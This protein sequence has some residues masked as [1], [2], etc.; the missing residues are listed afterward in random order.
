MW[1]LAVI[2][3]LYYA[4]VML[5]QRSLPKYLIILFPI[6]SYL[7][8]IGIRIYPNFVLAVVTLLAF[9]LYVSWKRNLYH[10][11]SNL[12][13]LVSGLL[14][15]ISQAMLETTT[16]YN[17]I[18]PGLP[19]RGD[20]DGLWV[21]IFPSIVAAWLFAVAVGSILFWI[22][23]RKKE[24][25][26]VKQPRYTKSYALVSIIIIVVLQILV[27]LF[28]QRYSSAS[29]SDSFS[30]AL[31]YRAPLGC[32]EQTTRARNV[33]T[34]VEFFFGTECIPKGWEKVDK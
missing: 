28:S 27:G 15:A 24:S 1:L 4:I 34:G 7:S 18:G 25:T 19:L 26:G 21:L 17:G 13:I 22:E 30:E 16:F 2:A 11:L 33:R 32:K 14:G 10:W 29:A 12:A 20:N 3:M 9:T 23:N 5:S 6:L 31:S 8:W